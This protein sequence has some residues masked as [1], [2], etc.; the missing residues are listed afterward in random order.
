MDLF[1]LIFWSPIAAILV[2]VAMWLRLRKRSASPGAFSYSVIIVIWAITFGLVGFV[3]GSIIPGLLDA[4]PGNLQFIVG[5]FITGPFGIFLGIV[6]GTL[7]QRFNVSPYRRRWLLF[8]IASLYSIGIVVA[9]VPYYSFSTYLVDG[10][11]V[12]CKEIEPL[13][14]K[15]FDY[16][17][18]EHARVMRGETELDRG[19]AD[20]FRRRGSDINWEHDIEMKTRERIGVVLTVQVLRKASVYEGHWTTGHVSRRVEWKSINTTEDYFSEQYGSSCESV[21]FGQPLHYQSNSEAWDRYPPR[22]LPAFLDLHVIKPAANTYRP[23][24]Q[25]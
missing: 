4:K 2:A 21:A 24:F 10:K 7:L 9:S 20:L 3:S 23:L 19:N 13:F 5:I 15:R 16:W 1:Q 12:A 11:I 8:G 18:N 14:Q 17:R 22:N 6:L 25:G